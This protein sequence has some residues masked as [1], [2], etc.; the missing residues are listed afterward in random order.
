MN[1]GTSIFVEYLDARR[2]IL[3]RDSSSLE[4]Y[5]IVKVQGSCIRVNDIREYC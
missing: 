1:I 4:I 3:Y 5:M 2:T